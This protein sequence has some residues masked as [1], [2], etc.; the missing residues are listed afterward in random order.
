MSFINKVVLVTGA[1]SAI[2]EAVCLHFAKFSARLSLVAKDPVKLKQVA[3]ECE[4]ISRLK[5]LTIASDLSTHEEAQKAIDS[6][7]HEFGRLDI[8]INCTGIYKH[9]NIL[10]ADLIKVFD[11]VLTANLRSVVSVINCAAPMLTESKGSIINI[12]TCVYG[13]LNSVPYNTFVGALNHLT[14]SVALDLAPTGIRVNS[15]SPGVKS[16]TLDAVSD[17]GESEAFSFADNTPL[18][19]NVKSEDVVELVVYLASD[20][21]RSMTGG[22]YPV[23]AGL[24]FYG[25]A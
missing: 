2:G 25:V 1:N 19:K 4:K 22:N 11:D 9:V 13:A 20:K 5:V 14:A 12:S 6:T 21:A 24:T 7:K 3:A 10:D 17:Q 23:D 15:I 18:G 16:N 8:I